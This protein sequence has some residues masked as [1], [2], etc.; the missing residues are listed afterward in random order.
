M[1]LKNHNI[2][3]VAHK[4]NWEEINKTYFTASLTHNYYLTLSDNTPCQSHAE[5]SQQNTID[6]QYHHV[7]I[8]IPFQ[9]LSQGLDNRLISFELS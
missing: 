1:A 6:P 8:S 3:N 7:L 9:I 4:L 2:S 5:I